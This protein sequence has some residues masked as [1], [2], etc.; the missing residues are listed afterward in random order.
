MRMTFI[1]SR[2]G[3]EKLISP[4]IAP[5]KVW[6]NYFKRVGLLIQSLRLTVLTFQVIFTPVTFRF[7]K[8]SLN[9]SLFH[10]CQQINWSGG[11]LL[12]KVKWK[13]HRNWCIFSLQF[14][15]GYNGLLRRHLKPLN[16][17]IHPQLSPVVWEQFF[18]C[19]SVIFY[20]S[21]N[22]VTGVRNFIRAQLLLLNRFWRYKSCI[23]EKLAKQNRF[24][25]I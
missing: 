9:S 20:P 23:M 17:F 6:V 21:P 15:S 14:F 2:E 16:D 1:S 10:K 18:W 24:F 12:L 3:T 11:S 13:V 8:S 7:A 4:L 22:Y 19:D 5:N 25:K